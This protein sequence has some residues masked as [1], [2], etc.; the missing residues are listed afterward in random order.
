[1]MFAI[2]GPSASNCALR[3]TFAPTHR[4][5]S[6]PPATPPDPARNVPDDDGVIFWIVGSRRLRPMAAM[7]TPLTIGDT[8][9]ERSSRP[10]M[11]RRARDRAASSATGVAIGSRYW[12]A[13]PRPGW[14]EPNGPR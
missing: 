5:A 13:L 9:V 3:G 7:A 12:H 6:R 4:P 2:D 8:P 1:M 11:G 10:R 14:E